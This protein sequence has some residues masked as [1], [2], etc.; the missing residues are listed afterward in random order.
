MWRKPKNTKSLQRIDLIV[1]PIEAFIHAVV[2]ATRR[3]E[4]LADFG[5]WSEK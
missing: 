2:N 1:R 5:G 3:L 4:R